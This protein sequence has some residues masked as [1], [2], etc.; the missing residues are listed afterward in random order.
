MAILDT[1]MKFSLNF[2]FKHLK[3]HYKI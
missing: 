2:L 1:F 3:K